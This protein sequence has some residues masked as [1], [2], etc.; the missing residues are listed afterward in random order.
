M[1][2]EEVISVAKK[3]GYDAVDMRAS[4]AGIKTPIE[5][6]RE[7][8]KALDQSGI[9][10]SC[11]TGDF[12]VPSNND[13]APDGLRNFAPYLDLTETLGADLIRIGMKKEEDITW[14]QRACDQAKERKIRLGHE[15]HQG[16]LFETVAG[17]LDV[18]TRVNQPNF[19]LI[20][21]AGTRLGAARDY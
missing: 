19:G 7:M 4:Q 15:S 17:S 2:F 6:L 13:K 5:R 16:T 11:I 8:R 18:L 20:D 21:D 14:A 10:V 12:D 1:G 9:K 3:I